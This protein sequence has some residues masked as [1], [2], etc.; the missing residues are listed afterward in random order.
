MSHGAAG[1]TSRSVRRRARVALLGD[2]VDARSGPPAAARESPDGQHGGP[3]QDKRE[4]GETCERQSD[5][6]TDRRDGRDDGSGKR[7]A[8]RLRSPSSEWLIET[9][10]RL[11]PLG[12]T[13]LPRRQGGD[14]R[15]A[16]PA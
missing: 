8:A 16:G 1:V 11:D 13:G 9:L 10:H 7:V 15:P 5:A 2:V 3:D 12:R 6:G 4:L 14:R